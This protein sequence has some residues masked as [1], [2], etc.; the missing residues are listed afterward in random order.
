[1]IH[2]LLESKKK[3]VSFD[4]SVPRARRNDCNLF[5]E[6]LRSAIPRL[7]VV[8][9]GHNIADD[10]HGNVSSLFQVPTTIDAS[11]HGED[12]LRGL[13]PS[14]GLT[15]PS[16]DSLPERDIHTPFSALQGSSEQTMA[17]HVEMS[18]ST[19]RLPMAENTKLEHLNPIN[20]EHRRSS[21]PSVLDRETILRKQAAVSALLAEQA[22]KS[23]VRASAE[24]RTK[25]LEKARELLEKRQAKS[26]S[27]SP[28]LNTYTGFTRQTSPVMDFGGSPR[29]SMESNGPPFDL[30]SGKI[31]TQSTASVLTLSERSGH[32]PSI[33][34]ALAEAGYTFA[35]HRHE[36]PTSAL[37]GNQQL[38]EQVDSLL[39][40]NKVLEESQIQLAALESQNQELHSE[41][42]NMRAELQIAHAAV[43]ESYTKYS[44][45]ADDLT[46]EI[47]RH[48]ADAAHAWRLIREQDTSSDLTTKCQR[49]EGELEQAQHTIRSYQAS[50]AELGRLSVENEQLRQELW[51]TQQQ[52]KEISM[53]QTR[54]TTP[55]NN[56]TASVEQLTREAEG[57]RRQLKGQHME[58]KDLEDMLKRSEAEKRE[59]ALK[60]ANLE[61]SLEDAAKHR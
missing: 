45:Q 39:A 35:I 48:Q 21:S 41:L 9:S 25:L 24:T 33:S 52:L 8:F 59:L 49:L 1:M 42:D 54:H 47:Q 28:T 27:Q 16:P 3:E 57:L 32:Q 12:W 58:M 30:S 40:K 50:N 10:N 23:G 36:D 56:D 37:N 26:A 20:F 31:A 17:H 4:T 22:G 34:P 51:H 60:I 18:T 44:L 7:D 13:A 61:H 11:D 38:K 14:S 43:K 46:K 29:L 6:P 53:E 2:L 5:I 55:S 19:S 15:E